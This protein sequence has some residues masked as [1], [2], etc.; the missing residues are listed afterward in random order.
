[1]T[2]NH[3]RVLTALVALSTT[4]V[5]AACGSG[6]SDA[7]ANDKSPAAT[8]AGSAADHIAGRQWQAVGIYT[9]PDS[10]ARIPRDIAE[11]PSIVLGKA[12]AVGS[13]GCVRYSAR[14]SYFD[15]NEPANVE[16][17][18]IM[19]IDHVDF[20]DAGRKDRPCTGSSAWADNNIRQLIAEGAEFAV[21]LDPNGEL[22]LRL[23]D[24]QV[25]SP[26]LRFAGL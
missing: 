11:Q 18:N 21:S 10:P 13:T 20:E 6:H 17:A 8:E 4:V 12:T 23:R 24:G 25:E 15:G 26:S 7:P 2:A 1:M 14:V 3:P 16:D 22:I 5:L 19:R 9:S